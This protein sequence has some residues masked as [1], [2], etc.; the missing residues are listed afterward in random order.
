VNDGFKVALLGR[1]QGK[2]L[3]Q[4]KAH[5]I[6]K[7]AHRSRAGTIGFVVAMGMNVAHEIKVLLH[8][9]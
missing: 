5:L 4:I 3:C 6:A 1:H 7:Y 9:N 8:F 2:T